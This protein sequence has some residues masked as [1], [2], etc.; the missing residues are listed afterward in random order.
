MAEVK[1]ECDGLPLK[2]VL[3][4]RQGK[5]KSLM[6]F[7]GPV[8]L[9]SNFGASFCCLIMYSSVRFTAISTKC[10]QLKLVSRFWMVNLKQ[11][12]VKA[13]CTQ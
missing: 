1:P 8:G 3:D 7:T 9:H 10:E 11:R 4:E 13:V 6:N 5:N 12:N 2:R